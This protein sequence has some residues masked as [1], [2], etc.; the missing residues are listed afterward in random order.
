MLTEAQKAFYLSLISKLIAKGLAVVATGLAAH[1]ILESN[2]TSEFVQVGVGT[3]LLGASVAYSWW[4]TKGE[5]LVVNR[6][7][8][9]RQH[10][11]SL[12]H[13]TEPRVCSAI[14]DA[15]IVAAAPISQATPATQ[16]QMATGNP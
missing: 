12:P 4:Q 8:M 15:K 6:L 14:I 11:E 3:V 9:L 1:G 10:V 16:G 13:S 2:D 7:A 5:A